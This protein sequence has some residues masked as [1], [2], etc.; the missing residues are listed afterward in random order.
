MRCA[1]SGTFV[2]SYG[3][4]YI[5]RNVVQVMQRVFAAYLR[6][7]AAF[8]GDEASGQQVSR[9]TYTSEQVASASTDAVKIAVTEGVT[10]IGMLVCDADNSAYLSLALW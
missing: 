10:V 2:S 6:L 5:G 3:I 8:F 7:P 9:V 1:A 4:S